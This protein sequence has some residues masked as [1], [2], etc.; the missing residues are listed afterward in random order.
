[1]EHPSLMTDKSK[2]EVE[3]VAHEFLEKVRPIV[4][5]RARIKENNMELAALLRE[6]VTRLDRLTELKV[7]NA[8]KEAEVLKLLTVELSR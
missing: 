7:K 2:E 5:L 1:M 6:V 8:E 3:K 4:E